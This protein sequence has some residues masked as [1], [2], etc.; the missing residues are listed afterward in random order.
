[1]GV[2]LDSNGSALMAHVRTAAK[3]TFQLKALG[4][5]GATAYALYIEGPCNVTQRRSSVVDDLEVGTYTLEPIYDSSF[6]S[7]ATG[8]YLRIRL[9]SDS[10]AL[11]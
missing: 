5:G 1:L 3:K 6:G 4:P 11:A 10:T 7:T 8:G 9:V 2:E